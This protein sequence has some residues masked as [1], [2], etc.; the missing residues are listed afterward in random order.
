M[1]WTARPPRDRFDVS[2]FGTGRHPHRD[3]PDHELDG[4]RANVLRALARLPWLQR[5]HRHERGQSIAR[6]HEATR[7]RRPDPVPKLL[8]SD[9]MASRHVGNHCPRCDHLRNDPP[10]RLAPPEAAH[11]PRNFPAAPNDLR[12]VT[13]VDHNVNT[14]RDPKRIAIMRAPIALGYVGA[15]H[16]SR[17]LLLQELIAEARDRWR[18]RRWRVQSTALEF[19]PS[20]LTGQSGPNP[21]SRDSYHRSSTTTDAPK[22]DVIRGTREQVFFNVPRSVPGTKVGRKDATVCCGNESGILVIGER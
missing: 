19:P 17:G 8:R 12:V 6:Q 21:E 4:G 9:V 20:R 22:S 5:N 10:L 16:R 18:W 1:N 14:I 11:D 2:R 3:G 7:S 15:E 13:D